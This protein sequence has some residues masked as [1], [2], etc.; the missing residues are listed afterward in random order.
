MKG[1]PFIE[2]FFWN[3]E[4][5]VHK[6]LMKSPVF[7]MQI[8]NEEQFKAIKLILKALHNDKL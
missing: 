3:F 5:K 7:I 2:K 1:L 6:S 8:Q 4:L